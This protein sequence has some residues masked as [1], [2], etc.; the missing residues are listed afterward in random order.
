[1]NG[2]TWETQIQERIKQAG[3][4][5]SLALEGNNGVIGFEQGTARIAP[6]GEGIVRI[7][8]SDGA[9]H[10]QESLAVVKPF[11]GAITLTQ[12]G[13]A[14]VFSGQG[15]RIT[16][17]KGSNALRILGRQDRELMR[18]ESAFEKCKGFIGITSAISKDQKFYGLG[19]KTGFL[20]KRGRKYTMWNTDDPLHTPD[21]DPLYKSIPFLISK[22]DDRVFG[23]FVDSIALSQFDLGYEHPDYLSLKVRDDL[24]DLYILDGA[25][26]KEVLTRYTELTGRMKLPPLWSLGYQQCRWSYYPEERVEQLAQEFKNRD[27]PCDAIYLDIDYMNEFRV[28]T[29]DENR[30]PHPEQLSSKLREQGIR[31][32]TII[33]P[34]VKMDADYPVYLEGARNGYFCKLPTGE[35]Y[36]GKVWPGV[37]AY[38]DFSKS[39]TRKWWGEKHAALF[40]K[41]ISGIWN[42]MNEPSDFSVETHGDRTLATVPNHVMMD[43][44]GKPRSFAKSHNAYG[45]LMCM[46]TLE[47]FN[48]LRPDERPF[49]VTR[50]AYAGIQRYSAVW[51][52]DNHS[53]WEHLASSIPMYLNIGLSGVPFVGGDVGGFQG[54]CEPELF[55]RWI[56]LGAFTPFFRA[57]SVIHSKDH[58]PW[59]FGQE[60]EK[61]AREAIKLRYSLM[62]Y[63]YSEMRRSAETGLP[64]MR[65]LVLEFENDPLTHHID[66]QFMVGPW[67]LVAPVLKRHARKRMVY[68]PEGAWYDYYTKQYY[69]GG[70]TILVDA[71]LDRIP[72]FVRAGAILPFA[73]PALSTK[74]MD[75]GR[76]RFEVYTGA[77][78]VFDLY[79]DDGISYDY[80]EGR[81]NLY[82]FTLS[83]AQEGEVLHVE[84]LAQGYDHGF[85]TAEIVAYQPD[86]ATIRKTVTHK[87]REISLIAEAE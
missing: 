79:E 58:E 38:P 61:V 23:L 81:Y 21:R 2:W 10:Q 17:R 27:I 73:E 74:L 62:P 11:E 8:L 67:L 85:E 50:S 86:G 87:A 54:E 32:V 16:G 71:P 15:I 30:F 82:R 52:G 72:L 20:D 48:T 18:L 66:D 29:F 60:V 19:E 40:D 31:L 36:H 34:G 43:F 1:M 56:Q 46:A 75:M 57:H 44:D 26:I 80:R 35:V 42:D 84:A 41:G 25:S 7:T 78:G 6:Y 33:D 28:F 4:V 5:K 24:L 76:L 49:I 37:S 9:I 59:A 70:T 63:L 53:W 39:A 69:E 45:L 55:A 77:A 64:L 68:L 22:D 83:K 47:G 3:A 12:E 13:D 14:F 51:T 65:P